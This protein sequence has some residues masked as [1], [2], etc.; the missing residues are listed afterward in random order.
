MGNEVRIRATVKDD[1]SKP[2]GGIHDAF[3]RLQKDGAKGLG[4]GIGAAA[5]V[6]AFDL[7]GSAVRGVGDAVGGSIKAA[8]DLRESVSLTGQVF[9]QNSGK[10]EKWAAG[11]SQAFGQS[12]REALA[13]A[14]NFGTA[15]KNVGFSLDETADKSQ[16]L[17]R[18]AADLGSAFNASS[19]EAATALRSGLLGESEPLRRFGVF[20]D[21]TKVKAKAAAMGMV[22][23][24]GALSDGQ[25][26]AARYAIIMEQTADSQGMFGRDTDSLADAQKRAE[27]AM[28]NAAA[29]LGTKL[30]PLATL[31]AK[32]MTVLAENA[33]K[34]VPALAGVAVIITATLIPALVK[35]AAAAIAATGP[36]APLVAILGLAAAGATYLALQNDGL[37]ES[38]ED[39][40]KKVKEYDAALAAGE[41][42]SRAQWEAAEAART[43]L[44][45]LAEAQAAVREEQETARESYRASATGLTTLGRV[46]GDAVKQAAA[47]ADG[48]RAVFA[49]KLKDDL[50]GVGFAH[51]AHRQGNLAAG[52][53]A[54]GI[55]DKRDAID[56]AWLAVLE[57]IK[58]PI[59]VTKETAKLLG[60]LVS[61]KLV[62]GLRSEDPAVRR[63]SEYTKQLILDRLAELEPRAGTLSKSAMDAVRRGMK[64]KDP[65]IREAAR[66][67]YDSI[68][69]PIKPA[70]T[71]AKS[72][73]AA[74]G[75]GLVAGLNA[76]AAAVGRAAGRLAGII[77]DYLETHSPAKIGPLSK[78]GGPE[79]WGERVGTLFG[80]GLKAHLPDLGVAMAPSLAAGGHSLP[81]SPTASPSALGMG[82][83]TYNFS[84]TV[85]VNG[86]ATPAV[87]EQIVRELGP[88]FGAWLR[89]NG[90]APR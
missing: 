21:E 83:A 17:T 7:M 90:Y 66:K 12:K 11:A 70:Q 77:A 6:K 39:L 49:G 50:A 55:L 2:I 4:V 23:L 52:A 9:E 8:S 28:E 47:A 18:L 45:E 67:I 15:L 57:G 24:N 78:S 89:Q 44:K 42:P 14:S 33:D 73:G 65:D 36:F 87:K 32:G 16:T 60:R 35:M 82:G 69:D 51:E 53:I 75:K 81:T 68:H 88:L 20:L 54:R 31:A 41:R 46:L 19:E 76:Q 62:E 56:D 37:G 27:T 64:S 22:P 84:P 29:A 85:Q 61:T 79:G 10:M 26:V 13:F 1:A 5:T 43:K 72:W 59:S 58:H 40:T 38:Y 63:Q 48:L 71:N 25:K 34:I 86:L 30:L 74:I 80:D 3:K